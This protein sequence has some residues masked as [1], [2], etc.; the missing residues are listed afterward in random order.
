VEER[1]EEDREGKPRKPRHLAE[2]RHPVLEE[3]LA[4]GRGIGI[5][6]TAHAL[7]CFD[8]SGRVVI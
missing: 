8:L 3:A 5:E 2:L 6:S 1:E 7:V 4:F